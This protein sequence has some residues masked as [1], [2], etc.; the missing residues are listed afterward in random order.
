MGN[1]CSVGG[2]TIQNGGTYYFNTSSYAEFSFDV[3]FLSCGTP[4]IVDYATITDPN[5]VV[6]LCGLPDNTISQ[7]VEDYW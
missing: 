2:T 4:A 1:T 3:N 6:T 5:G 7:T